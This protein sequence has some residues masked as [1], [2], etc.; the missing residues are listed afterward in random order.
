MA[1]FTD[2]PKDLIT[3]ILVKVANTSFA[4]FIRIKAVSRSFNEITQIDGFLKNVNLPFMHY[5]WEHRDPF[6]TDF[7]NR[8]LDRGNPSA[9]FLYGASEFFKFSKTGE[10][11][12]IILQAAKAGSSMAQYYITMLCKGGGLNIGLTLF[13][14]SFSTDKKHYSL[15]TFDDKCSC[16]YFLQRKLLVTCAW[17][18]ELRTFCNTMPEFIYYWPY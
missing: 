7:K 1:T 15:Y 6:L 14:K 10:G 5:P 11:Y 16:F 3:E 18:F 13:L 17:I 2:L 12:V 8:C 9:L 4:D